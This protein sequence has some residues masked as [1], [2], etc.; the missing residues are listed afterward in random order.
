MFVRFCVPKIP[1]LSDAADLLSPELDGMHLRNGFSM[2]VSN[3][4]NNSSPNTPRIHASAEIVYHPRN[5]TGIINATAIL[6]DIHLDGGSILHFDMTRLRQLTLSQLL[7]HGH[8]IAAPFKQHHIYNNINI[9]RIGSI[10]GKA[11]ASVTGSTGFENFTVYMDTEEHPSVASF[12]NDFVAWTMNTL[13]NSLNSA[14]DSS[15]AQAEGYCTGGQKFG[16]DDDPPVLNDGFKDE[17]LLTIAG[18]F[19]ALFVV[20]QS[21]I[22]YIR[23]PSNNVGPTEELNTRNITEPLLLYNKEDDDAFG[24]PDRH[25]SPEPLQGSLVQSRSISAFARH[26]VPVLIIGTIVLLLSSNLSGGATVDVYVALSES[27]T[28]SLPSLFTFSLVNTAKDMWQAGLYP[29]FFLV[30]IMSGIWPYVKLFLMLASWGSPTTLLSSKSRERLLLALDSLGK[31]ALVDTYLFVLFMVAFRYHLSLS[32]KVSVDVFVSPQTGFYAFLVATI[33]SLLAGH[34][35]IYYHRK[36][37]LS[38]LSHH[39][40]GPL[41]D[42]RES[43][44]EHRFLV[45]T[46]DGN[47]EERSLELSRR[48]KGFLLM[49]SLAAAVLLSIGMTQESFKFEIGGIAGDI[50]G[51]DRISYYSLLSLGGS[52]PESVRYRSSMGIIL[53][54]V[55]YYLYAVVIPFACLGILVFLMI[56]PM[57]LTAQRFFLTLA[58][59]T[60]AWSA[61]EVFS[62]SIIASLLEISTFASFIVGD[63]CDLIKKILKDYFE[64]A[65]TDDSDATCFTVRSSVESN[66][67]VLVAGVLVN[68]FTVSLLLRFVHCSIAERIK[69]EMIDINEQRDLDILRTSNASNPATVAN[70]LARGCFGKLVFDNIHHYQQAGGY[71]PQSTDTY[72]VTPSVHWDDSVDVHADLSMDT[73]TGV[74]ATERS[75]FE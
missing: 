67:G 57:T 16:F 42:Y 40:S 68:S 51:E 19:S 44:F 11:S 24:D 36:S 9:S 70:V 30:L 29:L 10:L 33:V 22:F 31:F 48:F 32:D 46:R 2:G 61:V 12:V 35:V 60:N 59:I 1:L 23:C 13:R 54:E 27:R 62:L 20:A 69:K 63:K 18:I 26:F 3:D 65:M 53:L 34:T 56:C 66:V 72:S 21:A 58:E 43:V 41:A 7:M 6:G 39:R 50:L 4:K 37:E 5:L 55:A 47:G 8:C 71:L 74:L 73:P 52:L 75:A 25:C 49:S 15:F 64:T 45:T 17:R 38:H 14:T 28:V